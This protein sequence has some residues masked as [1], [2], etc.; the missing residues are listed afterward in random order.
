MQFR[1]S[2]D[3]LAVLQ[4]PICNDR[5]DFI[6]CGSIFGECIF[7]RYRLCIQHG[8]CNQPMDFHTHQVAAQLTTYRDIPI[9]CCPGKIIFRWCISR[10][11]GFRKE[12]PEQGLTFLYI[13]YSVKKNFSAPF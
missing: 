10:T 11:L 13:E 8:P 1:T 3:P 6:E 2:N 5:R 12:S 4:S 9:H 7:D